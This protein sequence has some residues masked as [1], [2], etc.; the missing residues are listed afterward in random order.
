MAETRNVGEGLT[1]NDGKGFLDNEGMVDS[2]I[3][4]CNNAVKSIT[5]GQYIAFCDQM[6]QMV[7]KLAN[8]KKGIVNDL[9][10]R[11]EQ[12]KELH[13]LISIKDRTIDALRK[14]DGEANGKD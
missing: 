10:S 1:A 3:V 4:D 13:E 5:N 11:D 14:K 8:L 9:K 2:L 12:I 7:R 6:V